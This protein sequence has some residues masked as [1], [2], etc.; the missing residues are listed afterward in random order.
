[1]VEMCGWIMGVGVNFL[2]YFSVR[3]FNMYCF[4]SNTTF[5]KKWCYI[6]FLLIYAKNEAQLPRRSQNFD[7]MWNILEGLKT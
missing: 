7:Y 1:M 3:S 5:L 6:L 4:N 2:F